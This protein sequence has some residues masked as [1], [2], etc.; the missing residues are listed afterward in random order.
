MRRWLV[1]GVAVA[2]LVAA[3]VVEYVTSDVGSGD[4]RAAAAKLDAVPPA[5]GDWTSTEAPLEETVAAFDDLVRQGKIL[6]WGVSQWSAGQLAHGLDLCRLRGLHP[7]AS[8]QPVYNALVRDLEKE[9]LPLCGH[10]GVGLVVYSPLAQG[11]LTGKYKPGQPIPDDSRAADPSQNMFLNRGKLDDAILEKVQAL[12]PIAAR[13]NLTLSQLAL[14]WCLRKPEVANLDGS[15]A[16]IDAD[17]VRHGD[18]GAARLHALMTANTPG[19]ICF[20]IRFTDAASQGGEVRLSSFCV[21]ALPRF[22]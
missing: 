15:A 6:Y 2:G 10:E 7:I 21:M 13:N 11:L 22:E 3:A 4:V 17:H 1:I 8:N 14:A 5:F 9:V 16:E 12:V 20:E 18:V 19:A